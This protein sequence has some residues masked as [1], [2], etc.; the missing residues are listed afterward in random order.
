[1]IFSPARR[2][3]TFFRARTADPPQV[4]KVPFLVTLRGRSV[5]C[6][7]VPASPCS[8]LD[9][10]YVPPPTPHSNLGSTQPHRAFTPTGPLFRKVSL[11]IPSPKFRDDPSLDFPPPSASKRKSPA[12]TRCSAKACAQDNGDLAMTRFLDGTSAYFSLSLPLS[13]TPFYA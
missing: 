10:R 13:C 12:E 11:T 9:Q 6:K 2:Q 7:M 5:L 3:K 1:V 8:P 4:Q